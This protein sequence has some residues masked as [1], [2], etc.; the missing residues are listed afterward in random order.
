M[1]SRSTRRLGFAALVLALTLA[2][3]LPARPDEGPAKGETTAEKIRKDLDQTLANL[4]IENQQLHLAL[5]QLHEETKVLFVLDRVTIQQMGMDVDSLPVKV[6]RRN[7]KVR[8][9]LRAI[10]NPYG[11]TYAVVGDSVLVTTE[12]MAV[13]RQLKQ[14][15][16]VDLDR[17][18]FATAL[19]QLARE[20]GTNLLVDARAQKEAQA[21]VS[22]QIDDVPLE[23]AVR[24]LGEMAGLKPVRLGNV[25]LVTTK[26]HAAELRSEPELVVSP[27]GGGVPDGVV[28]VAVPGGG[29]GGAVPPMAATPP[30][31]PP[32]AKPEEKKEK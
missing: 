7:V 30:A 3:R 19:K 10:L 24:L 11:L 16:S 18:Q 2:A 13:Y 4:D 15:V 8:A 1:S 26:T 14:H 5:D 27:R 21:P 32:P 9:A 20:T 23:T 25:V 22:L 31:P 29:G 12:E 28:G 6:K 17:V